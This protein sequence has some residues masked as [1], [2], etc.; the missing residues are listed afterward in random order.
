MEQGASDVWDSGD[1]LERYVGRWSRLVAGALL[2]WLDVPPRA[3]WLDVGCG[4]GAHRDDPERRLTH[5]S[6]WSRSFRA[7]HRLPNELGVL[8]T[9][10]LLPR[11][12]YTRYVMIVAADGAIG[13]S[14]S[15][16]HRSAEAAGEA[17]ISNE[18][19]IP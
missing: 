6:H 13:S 17:S 5:G 15:I 11:G 7:V 12:L 19:P 10:R 2:K 4:P 1:A 18:G 3:R 14:Q 16:P 8:A 9:M